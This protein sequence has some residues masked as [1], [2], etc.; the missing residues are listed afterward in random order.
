MQ[1][2]LIAAILAVVLAG[3][4]AILLFNYVSNADNRAMA[5][6]EPTEVYVVTAQV[7]AGTLGSAL[8]G[9]VQK[10][11]LPATAIVPSAITNEQELAKIASKAAVTELQ[12]GEQL[13]PSHFSEPGTTASGEVSV[14][15]NMQEVSL[16]LEAQRTVNGTL[17]AGDKVAIYVTVDTKT[18]QI[19]H[20]VL[21]VRVGT[22]DAAIITLALT[23]ANAERVILASESA[24]IWLAKD[25]KNPTDTQPVS[26]KQ[27]V[28]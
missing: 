7:P 12:V 10:K 13:L 11:T 8:G 22:S 24:K 21:V 4:G 14:P 15:N 23:P 18:Q 5:N 28:G 3:I 25:A 26:I 1:R 6:L 17:Q 20:D 27:I 16:S 9:Y 19:L 2:R